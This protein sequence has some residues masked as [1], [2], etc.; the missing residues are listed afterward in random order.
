MAK[1]SD[2]YLAFGFYLQ[3]IFELTSERELR[4]PEFIREMRSYAAS[5]DVPY[6]RMRDYIT[7]WY[8][9]API[10][11][12]DDQFNEVFVDTSTFEFENS[13]YWFRSFCTEVPDN[14]RPRV[15]KEAWERTRAFTSLLRAHRAISSK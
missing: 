7:T 2:S 1:Y 13:R 6:E 11:F 15:R 9:R 10:I 5:L 12:R 3:G 14:V 8:A 4:D